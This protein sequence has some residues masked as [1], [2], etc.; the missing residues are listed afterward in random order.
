MADDES[1]VR[2]QAKA[3]RLHYVSAR[4][5]G[6]TREAARDGFCYRDPKGGIVADE[7]TI[8][9]LRKLAIPPAY[10]DVWIC[11]D[12][13]GHLQAVGRDAPR[14]AAI[15]LPS[16][17]A[18]GARRGEVRQDATVRSQAAGVAGARGRGSCRARADPAPG[19]RHR[20]DAAGTDAGPGGQRGIHPHQQEFRPDH[21]APPPPARARR[22][23]DAGFSRQARHPAACRGARPAHCRHHEAPAGHSRPGPVPVSRRGRRAAFDQFRPT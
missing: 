12:P 5:P 10:R 18:A 4:K 9:R 17:L 2:A 15:S 6:Y 14:S 23:A 13:K 20:G 11:A 21:P 7:D 8:A 3:A 19:A 1:E 22:G 16:G